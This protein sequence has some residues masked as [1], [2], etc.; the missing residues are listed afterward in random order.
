[1]LLLPTIMRIRIVVSAAKRFPTNGAR[2]RLVEHVHVHVGEKHEPSRGIARNGLFGSF[3]RR[4]GP[5]ILDEPF[6]EESIWLAAL[7]FKQPEA[8]L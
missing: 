6:F 8:H 5:R 3:M 7:V 2:T 1:M 4:F